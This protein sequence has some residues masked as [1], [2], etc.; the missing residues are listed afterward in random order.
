M[1]E[2]I[3]NGSKWAGEAPDS[4]EVLCD[5]LQSHTLESLPA[6]IAA[7]AALAKACEEVL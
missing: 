2:I 1:T 3:S 5:V 4:I 7:R 6:V